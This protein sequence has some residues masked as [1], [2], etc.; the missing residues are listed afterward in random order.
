MKIRKLLAAALVLVMVLAAV[1]VVSLANTIDAALYETRQLSKLETTWT[2]LEA[3]EA[4]AVAKGCTREEVIKAVYEAALNLEY[5]DSDSFSDFT[6]DGFFFTIDGMY[7]AYSYRLHNSPTL[8]RDKAEESAYIYTVTPDFQVVK[9]SASD[10]RGSNCG[11]AGSPNVLL[12]GPNYNESCTTPGYYDSSFTDQ[13]MTEAQ[14]IANATGGTCT[15]L[16]GHNAT[17]PNIAAAYT[18]KGVVIYDSHGSQSGT[19]S[20]LCL[21]TNTGITTTDYNN[22]WAVAYGSSEAWIDGRYIQNHISGSLSNCFVWMAICEGMKKAGKGTTGTA[23]LAAG[24]GGVYGYSQSVSFTGDYKYETVFWNNMK[25]GATV[26]SAITVMKNQYGVPDPVSGGDAYPIVMSAVDS[27]PSNPDANQTVYCDWELFGT[28]EPEPITS[29]TVADVNVNT[30]STAN[31]T[32]SVAPSNADYTITSYASSNT[33]VATVTS[34]GVVTGVAAGTSTL[35]VKVKDNTNNTTYTKTATITVTDFVGYVRVDSIEVGGEYI[36]VADESVSGSTGYAV[37]NTVVYNSHYLSA[38]GVT[39]D[40]DA[41][42]LSVSSSTNVDAITWIAGGSASAG[43][44]WQNKANSKYMGLDSSEYLYPS[45]TAVNWLYGSDQS[46]NNQVDSEGYYYLSYSAYS[47]SSQPQRYT[48]SK[49]TAVIRLYKYVNGSTPEPTYYTVTFKDWDGTV[50]S[51]QQVLEGSN[52]TA[53]ADPT[54]TGYTFVGWDVS[55][56][57]ITADTVVTAQYQINSYLVT[58]KDWDGTILKSENVAYGGSATPPADPTRTGYTS[59]GWYGSYTNITQNTICTALYDINTYTVRFLDWD[60]TVLKTQTVNYGGNAT[61]PANPT[62]TGYTFTG[63]DK[64]FTNVQA[65]LDVNAQYTINTYTVTF[66]DWDGTVLKTETV[67]YGGAATAPADPTRDGYT[68]TGWDV[69]FNNITANLTVTA[70]YTQ[71]EQPP[72]I[73]ADGDINGDGTVNSTD[74]LLA[75]RYSMGSAALT[76]EQLARGDVNGDGIV[77]ATDAIMIMRM[78]L[79]VMA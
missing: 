66:V 12:V 16:G 48:T 14:S 68:F 75:L 78:A 52:A 60:G 79:R 47:S 54:R 26:A 6:K 39:V 40:D 53:P 77:N 62:R 45:N 33:S 20:Y 57:N 11:S 27:F 67:N 46:F 69:A 10:L 9:T 49:N 29:V 42:T 72:V 56:T 5:V 23:L 21:T 31:V 43:Y 2:A 32:V 35:T 74:A 19:S 73:T 63:W 1:P 55:F 3:V 58:F 4:D 24:A 7:S 70:Q 25:N 59:T 34:S 76:D 8:N 17:G 30:G 15:M 65:N 28:S 61:A 50:L 37:G 44:T 51:T 38:V 71:N 18:N 64:A 41:N 22:G 36:L 13:Y